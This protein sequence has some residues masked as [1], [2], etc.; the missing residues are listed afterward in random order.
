MLESLKCNIKSAIDEYISWF[1]Y[2]LF[3]K[4]WRITN[5]EINK[6][7]WFFTWKSIFKTF[8]FSSMFCFKHVWKIIIYTFMFFF[9]WCVNVVNKMFRNI[10]IFF[11]FWSFKCSRIPKRNTIWDFKMFALFLNEL[12]EFA[13]KEH[14]I[15]ISK[16]WHPFFHFKSTIIEDR[17]K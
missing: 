10:L 7:R 17:T 8:K 5:N 15:Y 2:T 11:S 4:I 13:L 14:L 1:I 3:R 12:N 6:T 9:Q 16:E